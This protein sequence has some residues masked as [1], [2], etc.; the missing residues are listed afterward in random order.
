MVV[1]VAGWAKADEMEQGG[2][3]RTDKW[4]QQTSQSW[5]RRNW[6]GRRDRWSDVGKEGLRRQRPEERRQQQ[7]Q[8]RSQKQEQAQK[9]AGMLQ[10]LH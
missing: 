7:W 2:I 8:E 4:D 1:V 3:K 10:K 5:R 9:K 6:V